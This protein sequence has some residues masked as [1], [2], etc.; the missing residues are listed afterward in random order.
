MKWVE[1][2]VVQERLDPMDGKSNT[3]IGMTVHKGNIFDTFDLWYIIHKNI[4]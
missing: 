2:Y 1:E 3:S 4:R